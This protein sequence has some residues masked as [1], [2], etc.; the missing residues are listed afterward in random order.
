MAVG[1]LMDRHV[2]ARQVKELADEPALSS[3]SA[4]LA[5]LSDA[6]D[7]KDATELDPWT[8]LDLLQ[9][10]ARPESISPAAGADAE[11]K[12]WSWL[13]ALLGALVF[14]PLMMTWYGL[15]QASSAYQALTGA[16]PKAAAR[17][18]LQLW[19]SGFDG[20][21]TGA[22]TFGHVAMGATTAIALLFALVLVHG[23]RRSS[24]TRREEAEQR[25][26]ETLNRRLVPVLT[27]AQL[28]LNMHRMASPQRFAAELT[29]AAA[30]L[31]R[32]GNRAV[33]VQRDLSS[34]AVVVG[35]AVEKAEGRLAG[36]DSSVRPLEDAAGRI[37]EAVRDNGK[38]VGSAVSGSGVMVRKALEDVRD[39]NGSV[40]DVLDRAGDR[41]EDSVNTLAASQRSFT[42]GIEVAADVS[43][44]ILTRLG[45][46]VEESARGVTESHEVA[47][48]LAEQA[49][50]LREVA[51]RFGGLVDAMRAAPLP[52]QRQTQASVAL[53]KV[54][55]DATPPWSGTR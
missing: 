23:F 20:Y 49:G 28:V 32:L 10:F 34:A 51:E 41:V 17:P 52:S 2:V 40:R 44:Q 53:E 30:T 12:A 22:F 47:G 33:K 14:V 3:R 11:H 31:T 50:A 38:E 35:E 46:V 15:T 4:E 19:Q 13:E 43:A 42:T 7:S 18:F 45:E 29:E 8:D 16:N 24:V 48:R 25:Q 36:I 39:A 1:I 37:E 27:R 9:A 26:T 54:P 55:Q 6:F 5:A 21:L